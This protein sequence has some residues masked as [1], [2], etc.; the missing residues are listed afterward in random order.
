MSEFRCMFCAEPVTECPP[1][2]EL[3]RLRE[4]NRRMKEELEKP[5]II[6]E[7]VEGI[8]DPVGEPGDCWLALAGAGEKQCHHVKELEEE[9]RRLK[10]LFGN[11]EQLKEEEHERDR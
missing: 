10:E 6:C 4:E 1:V 3:A 11:S 2:A 8:R 5:F 9:I 7:T